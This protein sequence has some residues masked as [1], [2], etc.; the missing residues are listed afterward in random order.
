MSKVVVVGGGLAG[1]GAALAAVKAG[2]RVTLLER[3]DMLIGV[4]GPSP[5]RWEVSW[6]GRPRNCVR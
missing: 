4:S 2:A 5:R 3:T 1:Y 6:K